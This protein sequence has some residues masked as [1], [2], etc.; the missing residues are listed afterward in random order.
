MR[1]T[2]TGFLKG[3]DRCRAVRAT[4]IFV[5]AAAVLGAAFGGAGAQEAGPDEAAGEAMAGFAIGVYLLETG[6]P[7]LAIEPLSAAWRASGGAP[8]VGA[9]LARA[10]Y[11][12][13][14]LPRAD[15]IAEAVLED[16][17]AR[18]DML[19]LRARVSYGRR[20]PAKSIAYLESA[21]ELGVASFESER[22]LASLYLEVGDVQRAIEAVERCVRFDPSIPEIHTLHGDLLLEAGRTAEAEAAFRAALDLDPTESRAIDQWVRLLESEKRLEDALPV[23][24]RLVAGEDAPPL[25]RVRLAEA[26]LA[27]GRY[28]DGIRVLE[29]GRGDAASGDEVELLL[30]RL[31][32][33]SGR[34]SEA[35]GVFEGLYRKSPEST[36][37]ARILGDLSLRTGDAAGARGY[38]ERAIASGPADYRNYLALFFA[39][40]T[41]GARDATRVEL[42]KAEVATLLERAS[43]LAPVDDFDAQYMVGMAFSSVDSLETALDHLARANQLKTGDRSAMFN[44]AS[45]HEKLGHF[46]RAESVLVDLHALAPD[47]AAV[48]NFYGY[49]LA[50]MGKDLDHAEA[51][52]R[53]A[54]QAEPENGFYID[55]LGW[56]Y[57]KRGE[58]ARAVGELERAARIAGDD[59]VILE[60]LG[61]A[62]AALS[63]YSEALAAYRQSSELQSPSASLR[64]KIASAERR[65]H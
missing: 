43:T 5:L 15:R 13:R 54:L 25:A 1:I 47:D 41:R 7:D 23:L 20:D 61:D 32:F 49:L 36:E 24:E 45:V 28:D 35:K 26:Y 55:S 51:L 56:V 21:R 46:E 17:P 48:C 6:Q 52:V 30:G 50:E 42:S 63:R 27:A 65:G 60:H 39:Q 37:L 16:E 44:L 40:D 12:V 29:A 31:Y 38:F 10:Y 62:Y 8:R 2:Q 19:L 3:W 9:S 18:L 53:K 14:D 11:A 64:E 22:L 58:F 34:M 4:A 57:F 33:E 59:P